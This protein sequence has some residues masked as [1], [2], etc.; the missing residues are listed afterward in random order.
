MKFFRHATHNS[1]IRIRDLD[2]NKDEK[3]RIQS[4]EIKFLIAV[5]NVTLLHRKANI[6]VK[7]NLKTESPKIR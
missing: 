6:D 4:S 5:V 3:R 2:V 1:F 7:A